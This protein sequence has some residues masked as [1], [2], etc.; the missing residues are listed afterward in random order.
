MKIP[1]LIVGYARPKGVLRILEALKH[2]EANIY[3]Y[4][5]GQK[6]LNKNSKQIEF[7]DVVKNYVREN[8]NKTIEYCHLS[9]NVGAAVN[10]ITSID[11]CFET[12]QEL[13]ILEDDLIISTD[14]LRFVEIAM[15]IMKDNLKVKMITGTNPFYE[16]TTQ[17]VIHWTTYPL[18]WG[19][20][21]SKSNWIEMRQA[22]FN[23][24]IN[25]TNFRDRRTLNFFRAGKNQSLKGFVDAWDLP[26]AGSFHAQ[27]WKTLV[28]P[29]NLISNVGFDEGATHTRENIWPLGLEIN[30]LIWNEIEISDL[31]YDN[32]LCL[33]LEMEDKVYKIK[34]YHIFSHIKSQIIEKVS[35]SKINSLQSRI[36]FI[37]NTKR[38]S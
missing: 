2:Y 33:D 4:I 14:F 30:N 35:K 8:P 25:R 19:W 10:V 36:N 34:K 26:L 20:A 37:S 18:V 22:I 11:A 16:K 5:D 17:N 13:I 7:E 32:S 9:Q 23:P 24:K 27:D 31:T 1:V 21:T 15:P 38:S 28:P 12:E 6:S 29:V 3:V